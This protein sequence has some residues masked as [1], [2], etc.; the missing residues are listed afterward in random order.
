MATPRKGQPGLQL[1][2]LETHHRHA[3]LDGQHSLGPVLHRV[4]GPERR[5]NKTMSNLYS[6]LGLADVLVSCSPG[7]TFWDALR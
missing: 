6:H 7:G 2:V 5:L 4:G 3:M 1:V